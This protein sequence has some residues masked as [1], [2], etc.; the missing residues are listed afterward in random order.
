[1][2]RDRR[3]AAAI[4]R[5]VPIKLRSGGRGRREL[6]AARAR[7]SPSAWSRSSS[8][9]TTPSVAGG[10]VSGTPFSLGRSG[11]CFGAGVVHPRHGSSA[12]AVG[13]NLAFPCSPTR[14][15]CWLEVTTAR[16]RTA[17][18][19]R[20]RSRRARRAVLQRSS[21]GESMRWLLATSAR[22][23]AAGR[24]SFQAWLFCKSPRRRGKMPAQRLHACRGDLQNS[25]P[26]GACAATHEA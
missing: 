12:R 15:R 1:M 6:A 16:R 14:M 23:S 21:D 19:S 24:C 5:G 9:S 26:G 17:R 7:Y 22:G 3:R 2:P 25:V 18:L 10:S 11:F 13:A 8:P 4:A 20:E